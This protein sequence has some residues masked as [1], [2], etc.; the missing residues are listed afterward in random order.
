MNAPGSNVGLL[1]APMNVKSGRASLKETVWLSP[2]A[3]GTF[4][5]RRSRFTGGV[6]LATWSDT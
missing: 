3:S 2:G 5:K 1:S 4:A 6:M